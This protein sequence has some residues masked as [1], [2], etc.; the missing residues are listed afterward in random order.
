MRLHLL[1]VDH[2]S[3]RDSLALSPRENIQALMAFAEVQESLSGMQFDLFEEMEALLNG[4]D[5]KVGCT[6]RACDPYTTEAVQGVEGNGQSSNCGRTNKEGIGFIKADTAGYERYLALYRTPQSQNGCAGCRFFLMCKGQCPGTSIDGDWRNRT[7]HCEEWMHLFG[8]IERRMILAGKIPLTIQPIRFELEQRQIKAWE[9]GQNPSIGWTL[10][11]WYQERSSAKDSVAAPS[12]LDAVLP[13]PKARISWVGEPAREKWQGRL[14]RLSVAIEEM[15][16][17]AARN[18]GERCAVRLTPAASFDRLLALAAKHDLSAAILPAEAL[19]G[20][21][22]TRPSE[23]AQGV[24]MAGRPAAVANAQEAWSRNDMP[25]FQALID[26]PACCLGHSDTQTCSPRI[27][28]PFS[29]RKAFL[30]IRCWRRWESPFCPWSP[31]VSIARRPST[32]PANG[33]NLRTPMVTPQ[34][35]VGCGS[36]FHGRFR[37][38]SSTALLRSRHRFSRCVF[39]RV[40]TLVRG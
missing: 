29:C 28:K 35:P 34:R 8:V 6:W 13:K 19:P 20:G 26:L 38:L 30:R 21:I 27:G 12:E 37:G 14:E 2:G 40:R 9:S 39:R 22:C 10:S 18:S 17:H 32:P 31:A 33:W 36:A 4:Q 24:F 25:T 5:S 3:V 11:Q 1:E 15:T 16:V 23:G 7:E